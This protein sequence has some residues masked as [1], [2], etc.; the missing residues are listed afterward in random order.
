MEYRV[1]DVTPIKRTVHVDVPAEEVTASI[2]ATV[3]IY[4]RSADVKGFRKGKVP[5]SVI[6]GK[7]RKQIYGEA[8]TDLVNTHINEIMDELKVSPVSGIDYDGA[9]SLV[10]GEDFSYSITFEV[11]P[12]FE[13]PSLEG[14]SVEEEEPEVDE[15][16]VQAVIDRIRNQM[17]ELKDVEEKRKAQDG[18]V[19]MV[20]FQGQDEDGKPMDEVRAENFELTLG[21]GQALEDFETLVKTLEVGEIGESKVTFPED[22][23]NGDLA[24][25][26]ITMR[27]N[28]KA[29]KEKN[30]PEV[31]DELAQKAGGFESVDAMKE[32][33]SKSYTESRKQLYRSQAQKRLLDELLAK[34]DF[35]LPEAMVDRHIER[36]INELTGNLERQ[37][38]SLDS[39]GKTEEQ[40]REENKQ[41][42]EDLTRSEIYL[43][44]TAK[45]E[46]LEVS[47]QEL[48][49][50]FQQMAARTG[51][52]FFQL[53][54][55]H[56]DNNL[57]FAVRDRL[58]ADKAMEHL[59]SKVEVRPIPA[60]KE[61]AGD[62]G[63]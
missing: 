61:D 57:M 44:A 51:E 5:M 14:L 60:K 54:K 28:L 40:L 36:M 16:E 59:Y 35:P 13:L 62:A 9:E 39:T 38:K 24:G 20:T 21:E 45:A 42:A 25:R 29:L 1:E 48:D 50:F 58:L 7:Y 8:T 26:T 30:L 55:F 43:L 4:S 10:K 52:D 17:A 34:V 37:G 18:D 41:E 6:E 46:N 19:V 22:F 56:M 3:A 53:K 33:V 32:A 12:E 27:A 23:L 31:T 47:E 2:A 63:E 15:D 49:F 11:M